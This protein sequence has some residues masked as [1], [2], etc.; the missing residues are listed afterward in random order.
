MAEILIVHGYPGS[1]KSTLSEKFRNEGGMHIPV[2]HVS[3]GNRLR[4][5]RT[6]RAES[7]Y[8]PLINDPQAPSPL[9]DAVVS[10]ALFELIPPHV[11]EALALIDGYPRHEKAVGA[12]IE[13]VNE[14]KHRL[15]G[16]ISLEV[17]LETSIERVL[18]RGERGGEKIKARSLE[19]FALKRYKDDASTTQRAVDL[20][21]SVAAVERIDANVDIEAVWGSFQGAVQR[22]TNR[23]L[24]PPSAIC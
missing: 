10:G 3:A 11:I 9:P 17:T 1:G 14:R 4:D 19:E 16:C 21:G 22:L 18:F 13:S 7:Q 8:A 5:I 2:L 6:G 20:L 24:E 23:R 15:I 12:F